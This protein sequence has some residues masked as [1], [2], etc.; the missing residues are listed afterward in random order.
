M[1]ANR[2]T[3]G[4]LGLDIGTANSSAAV[5][6]SKE[7]Q[8]LVASRYGETPHGK[9]FPSYALFDL[10]GELQR[11][12]Q[13]AKRELSLNPGLVVWGVKRLIGLTYQEA[14]RRGELKR[15]QYDIRETADGGIGILVGTALKTPAEVLSVILR[16]IKEN[17]E[18]QSVN[19]KIS[20]PFSRAVIGVPAYFTGIRI[21]HI[22]GVA[23]EAGFT[24]VDTI[25]EPT[26][27]ALRYC[28]GLPRRDTK[29]LVFDMGAGTLDTTILQVTHMN[30]EVLAGE[31]AIAG[32]ERLGGIDMDDLLIDSLADRCQLGERAKDPRL[33]AILKEEVEL[34]KIRLSTHGSSHIELTGQEGIELTRED[35]EQILA[36]LL[37]RCRGPIRD[38]LQQARIGA[39]KI[40]HVVFVGGPTHMPCLRAAVKEELQAHGA[41]TEVLAGIDAIAS[42][43]FPVEPMA[44]VAQGTAL[45]AAGLFAP[46][47]TAMSEGYGM[48]F[49]VPGDRPFFHSILSPGGQ[50]PQTGK[51]VVSYFGPERLV[52]ID[53]VAVRRDS[54]A[55]GGFRYELIGL[56]PFFLEPT[57]KRPM[58]MVELEVT[59]QKDLIAR[60]EHVQS[61]QKVEYRAINLLQGERIELQEST[62]PPPSSMAA[63]YPEGVSPEAWTEEQQERMIKVANAALDLLVEPLS[64][65]RRKAAKCLRESVGRASS[66]NFGRPNKDCPN[67]GHRIIELIHV[68]FVEGAISQSERR[69]Y[70]EDL[71]SIA[72]E[73]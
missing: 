50:Y 14:L 32:D 13:G 57:R 61:G 62:A 18:N 11:V 64:A 5:A 23:R 25:A 39:E 4:A 45:K 27:A 48:M 16:D 35:L 34:A 8:I 9:T 49:P 30:Q 43:G 69:K 58:L 51:V 36:P 66:H 19:P 41:R 37:Q 28:L 33:K 59:A 22:V 60:L 71:A 67:I 20:T 10:D 29:I 38:A 26:A 47:R 24:E 52:H 17:A 72:K 7:E 54:E 65:G 15:F 21:A 46:V 12:G 2:A 1:R 6:L 31:L 40:D 56:E 42:R 3:P 63:A 44:C 53:F 68:L 73:S 55:D 70:L